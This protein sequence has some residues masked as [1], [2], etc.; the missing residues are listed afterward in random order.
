MII[1]LLKLLVIYWCKG[2]TSN[3]PWDYKDTPYRVELLLLH[4]GSASLKFQSFSKSSGRTF[5]F[6]SNDRLIRVLKKFSSSGVH[7]R[8]FFAHL[9]IA[10]VMIFVIS[11][12]QWI[13]FF[14]FEFMEYGGWRDTLKKIISA[15]ELILIFVV[16]LK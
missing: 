2:G 16:F 14:F 11:K 5:R 9:K 15:I 12:E 7:Q 10:Y 3:K 8:G 13:F 6:S 1:Y 4:F